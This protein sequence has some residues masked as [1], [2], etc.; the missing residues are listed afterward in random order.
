[1]SRELTTPPEPPNTHRFSLQAY[2]HYLSYFCS[3]AKCSRSFSLFRRISTISPISVHAVTV[4]HMPIVFLSLHTHQFYPSYFCPRA[5]S[6][7]YAHRLSLSLFTRI[8]STP[9]ISVHALTAVGSMPIVFL[10]LH[11]CQHYLSPYFYSLT[12]WTPFP[13]F[14]FHAF[15]RQLFCLPF[16][17]FTIH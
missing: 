7:A 4:G 5:N 3:R 11:A 14:L 9:P 12:S 15:S 2:Q 8:S 1:M 17:I 13:L 10:S 6:R 16:S